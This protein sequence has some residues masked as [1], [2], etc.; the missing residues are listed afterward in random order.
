VSRAHKGKLQILRR[1]QQKHPLLTRL[2]EANVPC[3]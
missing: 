3:A 1:L 2:S